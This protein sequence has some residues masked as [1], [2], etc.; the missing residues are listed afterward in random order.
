MAEDTKSLRRELTDWYRVNRRSLPW[1]ET[2]DP[3]GIWVSEVMLQQTQVRTVVPYY[4]KFMR[5]FPDLSNLAAAEL[6]DVLKCWEGLGYYGRARNLH[7]AAQTVTVDFDGTIPNTFAEFRKLKGVGEYI[8]SAVMSIAFG[9]PFAVVD[10]NVKRVLARVYEINEPVNRPAS[11]KAFRQTAEKLL[12]AVNPGIFNQAVMELGALVCK[13][14]KP[15]CGACPIRQFCRAFSAGTVG[16]Y[17]K[18]IKRAPIP[19]YEIAVGVVNKHGRMHCGSSR[20]E[21]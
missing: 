2:D 14:G 21:N 5:R 20:E 12:D 11:Q 13:P 9:L 1:R 19:S 15:E 4:N 7:H 10:G 3:Y 17:P 16:R 6:Q 8:A 18:R